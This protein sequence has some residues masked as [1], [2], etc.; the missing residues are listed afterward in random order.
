MLLY[1]SYFY[2]LF[3]ID[4]LI[5]YNMDMKIRKLSIHL[6]LI[7]I[8]LFSNS[9]FALDILFVGSGMIDLP[10]TSNIKVGLEE[11]LNTLNIPYSLYEEHLDISR[12]PNNLQNKIYYDF[13]SEKYKQA[14]PDIC[15]LTGNAATELFIKYNDLFPRAKKISIESHVENTGEMDLINLS[16][17]YTKTIEEIQKV[18]NPKHIYIIGDSAIPSRVRILRAIEETV[19]KANIPFTSLSDLDYEELID[20][21]SNLPEKSIIFFTPIAKTDENGNHLIPLKVLQAI[22]NHT[23]VPI[24]GTSALLLDSGIVGGYVSDP[25]LL[26]VA[27]AQL[28]AKHPRDTISNGF[29]YY[30]NWDLVEKYGYKN[31]IHEDSFL[32]HKSPTFYELYTTEIYIFLSFFVVLI[33]LLI[34]LITSNRKLSRAKEHIKNENIR[35]E[36]MVNERTQELNK[37]YNKAAKQSRTDALTNLYNRRAFFEEGNTIH[38]Y[39]NLKRKNYSL[40]MIDLDK[41]KLIN[42]NFGHSTGDEIL[43]LTAKS[44]KDNIQKNDIAARIGG[45]EFAII[46]PETSIEKALIT[47]NNIRKSI[48]NISYQDKKKNIVK[49]SVSIGISELLDTDITIDITLSRADKALYRAKAEGRNK[50]CFI[51]I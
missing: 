32:L 4:S 27:A 22:Y 37:L 17:D 51:K 42:D 13:L 30:Y 16:G 31:K 19:E 26:G 29:D 47:A 12:F 18:A 8:L 6:T 11:Q 49:T 33:F 39:R 10:W 41:F 45:E 15:V 23:K 20:K 3:A 5:S 1:F 46:L 2:N 25:K 40:L 50:V 9:L 24:F 48:E 14:P 38:S 44:I 36:N 35:L 21:V 28:I 43:K 7:L 34:L